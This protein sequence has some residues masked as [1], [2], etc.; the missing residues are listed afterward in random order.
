MAENWHVLSGFLKQAHAHGQQESTLT[1]YLQK[2]LNMNAQ[3]WV[4]FEDDKVVGVGLTQIL[5]YARH[6]TLHIIDFTG[7]ADAVTPEIIGVVEEFAKNN[8]CIALEQWG[9]KGWAKMLPKQ[10]PGFYEAYTVMRKKL[11]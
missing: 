9:R 5:T 1:D 7:S 2:I 6:K 4:V 3:C 10:I 8:G 11:K